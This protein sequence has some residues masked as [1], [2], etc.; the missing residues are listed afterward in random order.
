MIRNVFSWLSSNP[1]HLKQAT[2]FTIN[3]SGQSLGDA[4]FLQFTVDE[5]DRQRIPP[6]KVCFELTES[7]A[8]TNLAHANHFI[9]SLKQL[10]CSFA[11]DD[12]GSGLSSFGY[13]K[14]LPVDFLK[15]AGFFVK[16]IVNDP[17]DLAMV[18]SINEI[19][20]VMGKKTIAEYV[21][22]QEILTKLRELGVN[23]AQGYAIG[24][25]E[26]LSKMKLTKER[27]PTQAHF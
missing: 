3:L 13:L 21:E 6:E 18:K 24:K 7:A 12:F 16:D 9:H 22:S 15:I 19:G 27:N 14:T 17:I 5:F 2:L 10:G 26:R 8:I 23:L 11:L 20:Q 4:E 25:P 1:A